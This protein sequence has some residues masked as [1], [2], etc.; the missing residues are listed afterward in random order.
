[1]LQV[2]SAIAGGTEWFS[3]R[4]L[5]VITIWGDA[6]DVGESRHLGGT[7]SRMLVVGLELCVDIFGAGFSETCGPR[8]RPF[9]PVSAQQPAVLSFMIAAEASHTFCRELRQKGV[10]TTGCSFVCLAKSFV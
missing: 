10:C 5:A 9:L 8:C 2:F 7:A 4:R 6:E 1:M 3:A